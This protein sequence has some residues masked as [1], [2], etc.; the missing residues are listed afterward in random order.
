VEELAAVKGLSKKAAEE[1]ANY[2]RGAR[3][4]GTGDRKS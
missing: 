1:I 2:L 4:Q 3:V